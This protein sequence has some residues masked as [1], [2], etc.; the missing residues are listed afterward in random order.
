MPDL[1]APL[2]VADVGTGSGCL[3]IVLAT[4]F[5]QARVT[6]T[7]ISRDALI[8]ARR[9]AARHRVEDRVAFVACDLLAAVSTTFDLVV[10]NPPYVPENERLNLEPE[11]RDHEPG[12]A[13]FA[14]GDGT[15]VIE[16]LVRQAA[17]HLEPGGLLIFELGAGQAP[18]VTSLLS[19][20]PGLTLLTI[21]PDL[22]GIPRA[23]IVQRVGA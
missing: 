3:A 1:S 16:A 13:L 6:A 17:A 14:S 10:A 12:N 18:A 21:E 20:A 15:S 22:Q 7:D 5:R 23:A 19:A 4:Q 2:R 8:V 11:V 9:N